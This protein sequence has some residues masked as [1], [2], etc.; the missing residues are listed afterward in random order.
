MPHM[1]L[2]FIYLK[3]HFTVQTGKIQAQL[4]RRVNVAK[5]VY[6]DCESGL[7]MDLS[8]LP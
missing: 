4:L 8:L 6:P 2:K 3:R 7:E 1:S 5:A